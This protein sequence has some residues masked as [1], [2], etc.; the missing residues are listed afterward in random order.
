MVKINFWEELSINIL[1]ILIIVFVI[2]RFFDITTWTIWAWIIAFIVYF[3]ISSIIIKI[4]KGKDVLKEEERIS[5]EKEKRLNKKIESFSLTKW[6]NTK[7][8]WIQVAIIVGVFLL[9]MLILTLVVLLFP[10]A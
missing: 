5:K 10:N 7:K 1:V 9:F 4:I 8:K 6:W 3:G 2:R